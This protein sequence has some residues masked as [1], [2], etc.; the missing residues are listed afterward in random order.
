MS[1]LW[2]VCISRSV[3]S[4]TKEKTLDCFLPKCNY[5]EERESLNLETLAMF[6]FKYVLLYVLIFWPQDML[7]LFLNFKVLTFLTK[8]IN[9]HELEKPQIIR[10]LWGPTSSLKKW[11]VGLGIGVNLYRGCRDIFPEI[12]KFGF[13]RC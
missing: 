11:L 12:F 1:R 8:E 3:K 2:S 10:R 7:T 13:G 4:N 5:S 9:R 6:T